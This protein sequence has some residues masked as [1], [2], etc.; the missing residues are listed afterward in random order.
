MSLKAS[1]ISS[2][3]KKQI[4]DFS[5]KD[6][7]FTSEEGQIL[8]VGDGIALVSGLDKAKLGEL[9][10]FGNG[11]YGIVLNLEED[12]VG[13][14]L[15]SSQTSIKEGGKVKRTKEVV[16][17]GVGDELIG[18]VLNALG[19]PIDG[20]NLKTTKKRTVF[21]IAPGVMTRESVN[22]PLETGLILVDSLVPIGKG[23]RELIIGD[24][25]TGK[26]AIAIDTIIN[27]KGKNVNCIYV[28]IGQK[29]STIAQIVERLKIAGA[30]EYTTIVVAGASELSP[31]QYLAPYTGVTIAEEWMEKGKNVLIVYDDLTKHAISYRTLSLLLRRPPGREAYPGDVFYLHAQLLE[32]AARVNKKHGGGS[33]TALPIIE[34]QS[35][36]ISAYIPTNVISITDGQIFTSESL[37]NSGQRP[38]VD[39]GFSVSRVGSSA[40]IKAMKQVTSS[41]K[42]ELSQFN[43]M[44]AF[45]Q[46]SSD[47]DDS[48]KKILEHGKRVYEILKQNQYSPLDQ[49]IQIVILFSIKNKLIKDIPIEHMQ[50][51]KTKLINFMKKEKNGIELRKEISTKKEI[52]SQLEKRIFSVIKDF[53][54]S[55]IKTLGIFDI[56]SGENN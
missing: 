43:E 50:T 16:S 31:L 10:D 42:L 13:V 24:R 7:N 4:Q 27:Q 48:T 52:D 55:F 40:Q 11:A 3:I 47:L 33:I 34:T 20:K 21:R 38:A 39:V 2:I 46:F 19:E 26:T 54:D 15:M 22:E 28:A 9:L 1:D 18:R 29:N 41:L 5:K 53:V 37:F 8:S 51:F 35:G 49:S 36:D 12:A 32:R 23:Q 44:Q 45:A 14:A 56:Q 30:M 17:V 6:I 25:Q